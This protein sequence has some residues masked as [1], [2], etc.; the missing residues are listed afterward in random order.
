MNFDHLAKPQD[1]PTL[2]D[3]ARWRAHI[4]P[5]RRAYTFLADGTQETDHRTYA[6]LDRQARAIGAVLQSMNLQGERA[7]LVYPP[8]LDYIVAFFGCLY[9]GVVAIPTALPRPNRPAPHLQAITTDSQAAIVLTTSKTRDMLQQNLDHL[10]ELTNIHWLTTDTVDLETGHTWH[11]PDSTADTLAYLQYTSGS[12]SAPKGAMITHHNVL[13][14]VEGITHACRTS[15]ESVLVDW[16]PHFHDFGLVY[17]IVLPMYQGFHAILMPPVMFI[18]QPFNWLDAISRYRA[19]HTGGPNFAYDLCVD[20]ISDAERNTLDL[21]C[22]ECATSGAEPVRHETLDRFVAAF[23]PVGFR[24]S[25]FVPSYGL[26]ETTL[27]FSTTP[28]DENPLHLHVQTVALEQGQVV[29][30]SNPSP[31]S[32]TIRT[33][34]GCGPVTNDM[35]V[36]IVDPTRLVRCPDDQV[37]EIWIA[38]ASVAQGYWNRPDDTKR[39]FGA[40]LADTGE[41]PFLRT[42]DLGFVY[43]GQ[44]FITGRMKDLIIIRGRNH[45]PQDIEHTVE[46]CH[47]MLR[48]GCNAAFSVDVHADEQLV[49]VQE[50]ERRGR[51]K[52]D[53]NDV[54][55]TIRRTL[56]EHHDVSPYAIVL[57]RP[58]SIPRT[59]S[60]KIQRQMTRTAYLNGELIVLGEWHD[61]SVSKR[62][63]MIKTRTDAPTLDALQ[64]WMAHWIRQRFAMSEEI[65]DYT[66]PFIDYGLDSLSG[67]S[68]IGEL[69]RWLGRS[70]SPTLLWNYPSIA[71]LANYLVRQELLPRTDMLEA[72]TPPA[73]ADDTI[74]IVGLGCRFPGANDP[75]SFWTMLREGIDATSEIPADRW[76]SDLFYD[77]DLSSPGKMNT[78]RGGFLQD[79]D[80]FD[81]HF[82]GIAPREA[83]HMDPQQRILLEVT[84][85]ALEHAGQAP[86]RLAGSPTGVFIG[87]STHDYLHLM[88]RSHANLD[89]YVATGGASSIVAN[90]LSYLLDLR[91]P[92]IAIDTACSSSLVALHMACQSLRAGE[93]TLALAGGVNLILSPELTI[94]FSQARLMASDGRC[95]TFDEQADGYARGEG[96]GVVVLKRL[97]D[98]QRD[99]NTILA[100]VRGSAVNQD[101]RSNG[102][103]APNG[104]SQQAVIDAALT[105]A[106]V[107]PHDISYVEAHGTGTPLG[108][109]IEIDSLKAVLLAGRSSTQPCIVGSVKTNIGHLESA[110]GIAGVIKVVLSLYHQ[111]IPPHLHLKKINPLINLENTPIV[112]PTSVMPWPD[113]PRRLAGIS[114]FGF[115]GTNCH[116]VLEEAPV[117][118]TPTDQATRERSH[119]L[120]PLSARNPKAL[121]ALAQRVASFLA[122]TP[123][124]SLPDMC[125]TM[126]TGRTHFTHRLTV[127]GTTQDELRTQLEVAADS[128][129]AKGVHTGLV[130]GQ[131]V[132]R[133]AFLFSGQG[134]QAVGMGKHLYETQPLFRSIL[135]ECDKLLRPHL[136]QSLLSVLYPDKGIDSP[137]TMTAYTQPA[138]FAIE[139][140][141]AK[142]WQSWGITPSAVMGHSIGE[143]VAACIAGVFNLEDGLKL[144][145]A[146]GRLMQ[147]LPQQGSMVAVF[148]HEARVAAMIEPYHATLSVAG[149]NSAKETVISGLR[150]SMDEVLK[151][152]DAVGIQYRA[153]KVSHAFHSPMMDP[154][155]DEFEQVASTVRYQTPSLMLISN[156]T[157]KT[158]R[159]DEASSAHYWRNHIRQPVR[160][161]EGMQSLHMV[162]YTT[163]LE[164][165]PRPILLGLGKTSLS[166]PTGVTW[167]PS[168][169]PRLDD[170]QQMLDS[171][172]ILY[173]MGVPIDW[174]G[175]QHDYPRQR[176]PLPSYPFQRE[177]YWIDLPSETAYTPQPDT[178]HVPSVQIADPSPAYEITWEKIPSTPAHTVPVATGTWLIFA[179]SRGVGAKLADTLRQ[180]GKTCVLVYASDEYR[181]QD[182]HTW[183]INPASRA[184]MQQVVVDV[185]SCDTALCC[186]IVYLWGLDAVVT[187]QA[188]PANLEQAQHMACKSVVLLVQE[189]VKRN[190]SPRLWLVSEHAH[191]TD[192]E[193]TTPVAVAQSLLWGVGRALAHEHPSVWGGLVDV[194]AGCNLPLLAHQLLKPVNGEDMLALRG[195]Q[196]FAARLVRS[197]RSW[198]SNRLTLN[199]DASYLITGGLGALGLACAKH[200]AQ[201]GAR[202]LVLM[203]RTPVPSYAKWDHLQPNSQEAERVAALREL[204]AMGCRVYLPAVDVANE[205][206]VQTFV[207]SFLNEGN[208]PIRGVIH[209]AGYRQ[210]GSLVSLDSAGLD[211]VLRP[212]VQGGWVLHRT[213]QAMPLDFFVLF[214]SGA[215]LLSELAQNQAHYAAANAFLDALAHYRRAAGLPALSINWTAW[216]D[217]G[218]GATAEGQQVVEYMARM[219]I[220]SVRLQQG[221]DWLSRLIQSDATQIA[222]IP[223]N[224]EQL[225]SFYPSGQLAP[226]VAHLLTLQETS[227]VPAV[228]DI[229]YDILHAALPSERI[230]L[231]ECYLQQHLA[232]ILGLDIAQVDPHEPLNTLGMDSL[233]AI[234]LRNRIEANLGV[235]VPLAD[236]YRGTNIAQLSSMLLEQV[237]EQEEQGYAFV[238]ATPQVSDN[239]DNL[240][241]EQVDQLLRSML[242]QDNA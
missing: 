57:I 41:G 199:P 10:P 133:I 72:R 66:R 5:D 168:L 153:L 158:A 104:W 156:I 146:R 75:E 26:A 81:A 201:H 7:L 210:T 34:V 176:I 169:H 215:A 45:Y 105:K 13:H 80:Q 11:P 73:P 207:T 33:L 160:F 140:A 185:A 18:Q 79:V 239:L 47:P 12:T 200:L 166:D 213:M 4:H 63:A 51:K 116:I 184:D 193:D 162:G 229:S 223:T 117:A 36:A 35:R 148:A 181:I 95:K 76:H 28:I 103:T 2:A 224:W 205:A 90:R 127:M 118:V 161:A 180:Q 196:L 32:S 25:A 217:V 61:A 91:G 108:D 9:A 131:V 96:C 71:Q 93:C 50:V 125:A 37:G 8:G 209:A 14:N 142:L 111:A 120:L 99:G 16:L 240:S 175:V 237:F 192:D 126:S 107:A 19:T 164:I 235:T 92:S 236:L 143:Y 241:D 43:H 187:D 60:G 100:L 87:I 138:L 212:K 174:T 130:Q 70:L 38:G 39:A 202:H 56:I 82:F 186:G 6:D 167:L 97:S 31:T 109:P 132:P 216:A 183:S 53:F 208:P 112:I 206:Q 135:D 22:L 42:G 136:A 173:T 23:A 123:D 139:Y 171:L 141:L 67:V 46:T 124:V 232:T 94:S 228:Q 221:M 98:A 114:S 62:A 113:A 54:I 204:E 194:Q 29:A 86:D 15:S 155:L 65:V 147:S 188:S 68:M 84:W 17:C 44:V 227:S 242:E 27:R 149:I 115:G 129:T 151:Q 191:Q 40:Y 182:E 101:G 220:G 3:V 137:I 165:G 110:A 121:T 144:V 222:I 78:R 88:L 77:A 49:V 190:Q 214:S 69:E 74:A 231:L 52:M 150:E 119:H 198:S 48:Q 128:R 170:W 152:F 1:F 30:V 102:M 225:A 163:F 179:D 177:S 55:Q 238:E 218:A 233:M 189:L 20:K 85:E 157:G 197:P 145:A 59:T 178:Q 154:I 234:E 64:K 134:A 219:G 172:A 89:A 195:D 21:N 203:G 230:T 211:A 24:R 83:V 122:A 226:F 106:G 159:D 58:A